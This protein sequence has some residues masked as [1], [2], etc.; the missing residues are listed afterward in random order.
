MKPLLSH[1]DDTVRK[2]YPDIPNSNWNRDHC[3]AVRDDMLKELYSKCGIKQ[4][5]TRQ[6]FDS[7]DFENPNNALVEE[8]PQKNLEKTEENEDEN[9]EENIVQPSTPAKFRHDV[10]NAK[11]K[12]KTV[13][14]ASNDPSSDGIK[15]FHL[16]HK[17]ERLYVIEFT[18][19]MLFVFKQ[20]VPVQKC[21]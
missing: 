10:A 6:P 15:S 19:M 7:E 17:K 16:V 20:Q 4:P 5:D 14:N 9:I 1:L 18:F 3:R 11:R 2:K 13:Q 12:H 8:S 21:Q